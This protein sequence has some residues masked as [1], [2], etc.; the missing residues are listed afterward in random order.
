M[1]FVGPPARTVIALIRCSFDTLWSCV[2]VCVCVFV[3]ACVCVCVKIMIAKDAKFPKTYYMSTYYLCPTVFTQP[4][5]VCI[6]VC[7]CV[8]MCA[9]VFALYNNDHRVLQALTN[10]GRRFCAHGANLP[11]TTN[12]CSASPLK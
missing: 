6:C 3:R 9:C 2:C 12:G 5:P 10:T 11:P 4:G 8:C 7:V 1:L